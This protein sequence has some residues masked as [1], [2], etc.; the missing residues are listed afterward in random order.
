MH[1]P[2]AKLINKVK[3]KGK[4]DGKNKSQMKRPWAENTKRKEW[5][6]PLDRCLNNSF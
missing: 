6:A 4:I 1:V 5:F 2:R 3:K